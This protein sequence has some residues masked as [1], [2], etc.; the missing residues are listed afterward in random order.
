[1][2][3]DDHSVHR[4]ALAGAH[5]QLVARHHLGDRHVHFTVAPH[6]VGHIGPQRMQ[7]ADGR[8]GLP[9]GP[10]LQPLAQQHQRDHHRRGLEVQV[11][12]VARMRGEP[13]PQGQPEARAGA[14]RHQQVHVA[15][16]RPG[17][18]PA[19]LVEARTQD[20]LHGRGQQELRPGWQHP[21]LAEQVAEHRQH[22]RRGQQQ[23]DRDRHEAR[24]G[25]LRFLARF[26]LRHGARLVARIAHRAAQDRIDIGL[27]RC[28]AERDVCTL[29]GQVH[30]GVLHAWNLAQRTLDAPHAARAG[31]AADAEIDYRNRSWGGCS[32]VHGLEVKV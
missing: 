27:R 26:L 31:H 10:G 19:R 14:D 29:G 17:R 22:Q 13:Q 2:T 24:P 7:R 8:R 11:R 9:L 32:V 28:I 18:M 21:V 20:E 16:Q 5:H 23:A 12:R 4:H 6:Q 1:M 3:L 30:R 25:R 15:R